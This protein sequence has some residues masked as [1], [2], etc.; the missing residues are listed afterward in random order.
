MFNT[1]LLNPGDFLK[2][3]IIALIWLFIARPVIAKLDN[4]SGSK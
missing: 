4:P 2:I 3:A 1:N